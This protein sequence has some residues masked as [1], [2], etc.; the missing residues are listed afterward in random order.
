MGSKKIKVLIYGVNG[1]IG[2]NLV[3]QLAKSKF[4]VYAVSSSKN[5]DISDKDYYYFKKSQIFKSKKIK[6]I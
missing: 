1:F 6:F 3:I 4:D 5:I 2:K